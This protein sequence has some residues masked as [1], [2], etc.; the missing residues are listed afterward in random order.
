MKLNIKLKSEFKIK[1]LFKLTLLLI[2]L[3]FLTN[4][5]SMTIASAE[6]ETTT[7]HTLTH[8]LNNCKEMALK[9]SPAILA[10]KAEINRTKGVI[11]EVWTSILRVNAKGE[12][13]YFN[14]PTPAMSIPAGK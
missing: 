2:S 12:Y 9:D 1:S 6:T 10:A 14:H 8:N 7:T 4:F 13:M 3:T 11:W 5:F